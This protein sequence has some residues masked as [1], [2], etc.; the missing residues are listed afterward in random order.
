MLHVAYFTNKLFWG[1][2]TVLSMHLIFL[3]WFLILSPSLQNLQQRFQNKT[4]LVVMTVF[5]F[6]IEMA[7]QEC[8]SVT[9][10]RIHL[11]CLIPLLPQ[12]VKANF[13]WKQIWSFILRCSVKVSRQ[14]SNLVS[15]ASYLFR[16]TTSVSVRD[17]NILRQVQ[18]KLF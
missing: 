6:D 9:C 4:E 3:N 7:P 11:S 16:L 12:L 14:F 18:M 13:W 5:Y 10:F 1:S 15:L 17:M 2:V 8:R